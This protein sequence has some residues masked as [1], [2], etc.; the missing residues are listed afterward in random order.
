MDGRGRRSS[1]RWTLS[2]SQID[3]QAGRQA[4]RQ[5]AG[6]TDG[7]SWMTAA[8]IAIHACWRTELTSRRARFS[9]GLAF[10]AFPDKSAL[11]VGCGAVERTPRRTK[12][13]GRQKVA[14]AKVPIIFPRSPFPQDMVGRVNTP[15]RKSSG[16]SGGRRYASMH[17]FVEFSLMRHICQVAR[18]RRWA[19]TERSMTV[20]LANVNVMQTS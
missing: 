2:K 3:R 6:Q 14:S 12:G 9:L 13:E 7:S 15:E 8:G 11:A 19:N 10:V 16:L 1:R 20:Y 17:L 4:D 5:A 18:R